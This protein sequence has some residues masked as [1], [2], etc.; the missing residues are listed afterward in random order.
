MRTLR[1][2]IIRY[3]LAIF[4]LPRV[5][6]EVAR[7]AQAFLQETTRYTG[8]IKGEAK[9]TK[10]A[11]LI[12]TRYMKREKLS[13]AER[14]QFVRQMINLLKGTG[15]VVPVLLIPFPFVGTILLVI[16]DH[17]LMSM[18]IQL[19]PSSF[20]PPKGKNLLTPEGIERDLEAE[21]EGKAP[22]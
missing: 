13:S 20:Y 11:F 2:R 1:K 18:K 14:R 10:V 17:L 6:T 4:T 8:G 21:K 12:L 15:V 22:E 7:Y 16:M 19:L 9:E 5:K 3:L